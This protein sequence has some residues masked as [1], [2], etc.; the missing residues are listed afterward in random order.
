MS[1]YGEELTQDE[2]EIRVALWHEVNREDRDKLEKMQRVLSSRYAPSG[3]LA[4]RDY[5]GT[6]WDFYRYLGR[7]ALEAD[8]PFRG[9]SEST[10]V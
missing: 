10:T 4:P 2:L 5:E 6:I 8:L 9:R 3:A 1:T 7:Q